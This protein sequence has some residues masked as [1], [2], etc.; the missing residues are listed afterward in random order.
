MND[1]YNSKFSNNGNDLQIGNQ[2]INMSY[3][4]SQGL[5][6]KDRRNEE[7]VLPQDDYYRDDI[8]RNDLNYTQYTANSALSSS[9]DLE[10]KAQGVLYY[11]DCLIEAI[12]AYVRKDIPA[13]INSFRSA[14]DVLES[15]KKT[16]YNSLISCK[17]N[18]GIAHFYNSQHDIAI[19]YIQEAL[20]TF[21]N[22]QESPEY[23]DFDKQL[24]LLKCWCNLMIIKMTIGDEQG[25]KQVMFDLTQYL[26]KL[27]FKLMKF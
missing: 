17:C 4:E 7:Q 3:P 27:Y 9:F 1:Y 11:N 15:Q 14:L 6:F 22:F 12:S 2:G 8:S 10:E 26:Q 19:N 25:Y 5:N 23:Y 13:L 16:N 20:E 24:L 18:L 21:N